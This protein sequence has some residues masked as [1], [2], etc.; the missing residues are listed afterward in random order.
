MVFDPFGRLA[1]YIPEEMLHQFIR[2]V[3]TLVLI[4]FLYH[5]IRQYSFYV[6]KPLWALESLLYM[7]LV[8]AFMFR[9]VPCNR[10]RGLQ[11][12]VIPVVGSALPFAL[13]LSPPAQVVTE[14]SI[15][16]YGA[17]WWMTAATSLTV[18]GMWSLRRA[19]SITVEA[20]SIISSVT[21]RIIRHPI[22]LGEMLAAAGVAFIRFC[23][24]NAVLLV[25]FVSI[26]LFRSR[27]EE[28]KLT[29]TFPEYSFFAARSRWFW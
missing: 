5:R 20:R 29:I 16:L 19:F 9:S 13:L 10:S 15:L 14:N 22:Y 6:V 24:A 2:L 28:K 12:I 25:L 3:M 21:Y 17:L 7:V 27:M 8:C 26:Q 1:R 18:A 4:V 11:E 23:P